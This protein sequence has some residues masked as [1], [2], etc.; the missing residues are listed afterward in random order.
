M[1]SSPL[2]V[3]GSI[4][5]DLP[6]LSITNFFLLATMSHSKG[7]AFYI[8]FH[9]E[10]NKSLFSSIQHAAHPGDLSYPPRLP[11]LPFERNIYK[12]MWY[13]YKIMEAYEHATLLL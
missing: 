3:V 10:P 11:P 4:N 12:V 1:E 13:E 6:Q 7:R 2:K 8:I 5:T 9:R